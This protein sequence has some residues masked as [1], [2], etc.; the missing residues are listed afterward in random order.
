[1]MARPL[2]PVRRA[3]L[4]GGLCLL[5]FGITGFTWPRSASAGGTRDLEDGW[6]VPAERMAEILPWNVLDE[7]GEESGGGLW[8]SVG[9]AHLFGLSELSLA[10]LAVGGGWRKLGVGLA[11]QRLGEGLFREDR[12]RVLVSVGTR[13]RVLV[14]PGWDRLL[15][16]DEPPW[17]IPT[18]DLG[19]AFPLVGRVNVQVVVPL[20]GPPPWHGERSQ[21]RWLLITGGRPGLCGALA[22][23]R[24]GTGQPSL[25][26]ALLGR[27]A[28]VVALG[29]RS[30]PATGSL[31][32]TT[33]WRRRGWLLRSSHLAHPD[34]GITHRWSLTWGHWERQR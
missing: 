25:Q 20:R 28:P 9:Q 23:D 14:Q 26:L 17:N 22:I 21:R 5:L 13:W 7:R 16:A 27:A 1:M 30:E 11:W 24:G 8:I 32:L 3:R 6:L 12:L 4:V 33:V 34:L 31:G 18:L 2:H 29:L 10:R 15:L 19:L